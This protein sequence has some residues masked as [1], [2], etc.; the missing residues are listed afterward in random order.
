MAPDPA[1]RKPSDRSTGAVTLQQVATRA[2]VSIATASRALHGGHGR[3][4]NEELR[5]RVLAAAAELSYVS[6][7]PAQALARSRTSV[8]GLLVHDVADPYFGAIATGVM[9]AAAE[10][11]LMVMLAASFREPQLELDYL[12]RLRTQRARAIV[13][14]GSGFTDQAFTARLGESLAGFAE[15]GGRVVCVGDHGVDTDTVNLDNRDGA[16]QAVA[17]LWALGHRRIGVIAGP[18]GLVTVR[19]RLDGV[20]RALQRRGAELP[21]D[22]LVEADFTRAGGHAAALALF[23]RRPDLTAVFALNDGMAAGALAA[24][25]EGLGRSVPGEVSVVGFDDLP[26]S[27]DLHPSLTTVRLPLRRAGQRALELIV[28]ERPQRGARR[29]VELEADLTVRASTGPAPAHSG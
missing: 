2:G 20:R 14:A 24:L 21:A 3:V 12:V 18:L 23:A 19:D 27:A 10:F 4:V 6:N 29:I 17:H 5:S 28:D 11:D 25:Q 1:P 8:V 26:Y 9:R 16:E 13:L 7:A 15:D 22:C